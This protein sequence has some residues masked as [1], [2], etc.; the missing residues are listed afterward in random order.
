LIKILNITE[1]GRGGGALYRIVDIAKALRGQ[2]EFHIVCP[3]ESDA[4]TAKLE[5][6]KIPYTEL[7]LHYI[8]K[9]LSHL[10]WYAL[11]FIPEVWQIIQ[12]IKKQKP[13][14]VYA[15][16]SWQIKGIIAAKL[17]GVK[18]LW[19]MNDMYQPKLMRI[20]FKIM[21]RWCQRYIY[22]SHRTKDYYQ[23]MTYKN[24][25]T[26]YSV[27]PAPVDTSKFVSTQESL[28]RLD[29]FTGYKVLT[30]GYVNV[31]KG[32]ETLID[33][34]QILSLEQ[35][36]IK[37]DFIIAGPVLPTRQGYKQTLDERIEKYGLSNIHFIGFQEDTASLINSCDVYLCSSIYESSPIA[38][39]EALSCGQKV[40]STEVGD[41][42]QIF[43]EYHC[44]W[45]IPI[46]D[47]KQMADAILYMINHPDQEEVRQ[48][49]AQTAREIFSLRVVAQRHLQFY[50]QLVS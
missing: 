27:I 15:N 6:E 38:V 36:E 7:K 30:I 32:L 22:A 29:K 43:D 40:I 20:V 11:Y 33:A 2:V 18:S 19:H 12:L 45:A 39:W 4:F 28:H 44:G 14:L 1:E 3:I 8:T 13:D 26:V 47:A 5:Q 34:A 23:E 35:P 46:G 49:A 48:K 37:V 21:S 16:G 17:A 25:L 41:I 24:K 31:N 10:F 50:N 9:S 42:Q